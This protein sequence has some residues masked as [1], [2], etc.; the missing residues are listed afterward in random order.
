MRGASVARGALRMA[1][2]TGAE[3]QFPRC[4]LEATLGG[5]VGTSGFPDDAEVKNPLT[6]S[7]DTDLTPG[8][9][10]LPWRRRK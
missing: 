6:N 8:L 10:R 5:H 4:C 2:I 7:A 1:P 3:G 9:G